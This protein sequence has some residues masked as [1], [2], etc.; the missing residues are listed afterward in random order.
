MK[1]LII[2][3]VLAVLIAIPSL[4][5][6]GYDDYTKCAEQDSLALVAF[7]HATGGPNWLSN[8]KED[9][10]LDDLS[11]FVFE[12]YTDL[13]PHAG[14]GKWLEG[15]VKDWFGV[16]LEKQQIG[17]TNE[18]AWR[19]VD[20]LPV[21]G[22]REAGNNNLQG[23][24]PKELGYL[25]ALKYFRINGNVGLYGSEL[26]ESLFHP[27]LEMFDVEACQLDGVISDVF[28]K[29]TKINYLNL[30]TNRLTNVPVMDFL[31]HDHL[32]EHFGRDRN[33]IFYYTNRIPYTTLEKS[34]DYF[35]SD[36]LNPMDIGYE[37][38]Q[39]FD[40]GPEREIIV[41]QG[42]NVTVSTDVGGRDAEYTWFRNGI[43]TYMTGPSFTINNIQQEVYVTARI[44]NEYIR[45][46]DQNSGGYDNVNTSK[47]NI[48]FQPIAP[49]IKEIRT[50]YSGQK[51]EI[52]F[53]KPMAVPSS[54]DAGNF[55]VSVEGNSISGKEIIRSGINNEILIVSLDSPVSVDADVSLSYNAGSVVCENGGVLESFSAL[56]V[57]NL[58]RISPVLTKVSSRTDGSGI[59]MEFDG[60]IDASTIN[61]FDFIVSA[62]FDVNVVGAV[63]LPGK[64][65]SNISKTIELV[66]DT[67][68]PPY[69][70]NIKVSF[71]PG[72][73]TGLYGGT[74]QEVN[75]FSVENLVEDNL[76]E[77]TFFVNDGPGNFSNLF[78]SGNM[79]ALPIA[80]SLGE[81]NLWSKTIELPN[82]EYIWNVYERIQVTT[83]DTTY[84]VENG[85]TTITIKPIVEEEDVLI[86]VGTNLVFNV[87]D[88]EYSGITNFNYRVFNV[89]FV[90]DMNPFIS[91]YPD[92][93][94]NPFLM[95]VDDDWNNGLLMTAHPEKANYYVATISNFEKGDVLAF[96]FRNND[97]WENQTPTMRYHTVVGNDVINVSFGDMQVNNQLI[98]QLSD[99]VV[100]PNPAT[101]SITIAGKD[102]SEI[103]AVIIY[104]ANGHLINTITAPVISSIDVSFLANGIYF[105]NVIAKNEKTQFIRFIKY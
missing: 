55:S 61:K 104:N 90:L 76:T 65:N 75:D 102:L 40:L 24:I 97:I 30:R 16:R 86:S 46:H 45:L 47:I 36:G 7:Y 74:V 79:A 17:S 91:L 89:T 56:E 57:K 8:T 12:F 88:K 32:L 20:L 87:L 101:N 21:V 14:M 11:D 103:K 81:E 99:F 35:L 60:F 95:G 34:L 68:L 19:V 23:Y 73:L 9:F 31:T 13:Y 94:I 43:N 64:I 100:Y 28:R 49:A 18:Y 38:R 58:M 72:S 22:R 83:Y 92:T 105:L 4:K 6:E 50:S 59:F 44:K 25:T 69:D 77:V 10:G 33:I 37:A 70:D 48:R 26:P 62:D 29:C 66:L 54:G 41:N 2:L 42:E 71:F 51:I 52:V 1:Q 82:G 93:V 96:N 3:I 98:E 85:I 78:V 84:V 5:A 80:L 27:T 15:P 63:L 67:N 53:S 39:Q